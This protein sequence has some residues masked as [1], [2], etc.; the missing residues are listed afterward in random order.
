MFNAP[1]ASTLDALPR[2]YETDDILVEDKIIHVHFFIGTSHW[3]I[4][5]YNPDERI[6]FGFAILA[7]DQMCAEWGYIPY[8]E[9]VA[10][11]IDANTELTIV[12]EGEDQVGEIQIPVE[13]LYDEYW[14]PKPFRDLPE[15]HKPLF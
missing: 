3:Y 9:L 6:F 8:D 11:R 12:A 13:V 5:E 15:E 14:T 4:A 1:P 2:F 7:G 10:I